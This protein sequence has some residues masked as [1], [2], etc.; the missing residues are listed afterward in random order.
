MNEFQLTRAQI[1]K[2]IVELD[3]VTKQDILKGV[4]EWMTSMNLSDLEKTQILND[5]DS[6]PE[7][8]LKGVN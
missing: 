6:Y 8:R 3:G 2:K 5:L 1:Q 4:T 7:Y